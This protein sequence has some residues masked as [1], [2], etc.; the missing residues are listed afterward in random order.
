M[1]QCVICKKGT[2]GA[3]TTTLTIERDTTTMVIK[4]VPAMVCQQCGEAYLSDETMESLEQIADD[5][6]RQGVQVDIRRF[7]AA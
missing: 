6:A 7:V 4:E 1:K 5:A 2:V 3:G